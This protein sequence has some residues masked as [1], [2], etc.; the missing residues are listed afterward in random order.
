MIVIQIRPISDLQN[1]YNAIEKEILENEQTVY[2]TKNG[3]GSMV[4]MNLEDYSRLT[5][6]TQA[7]SI[8]ADNTKKGHIEIISRTKKL[9]DEDDV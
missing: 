9:V 2:L 7:T 6:P 8:Q 1:D 3:Y 5:E 4:M